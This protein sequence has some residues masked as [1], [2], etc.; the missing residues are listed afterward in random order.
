[1]SSVRLR[2][3][4]HRSGRRMHHALD[5]PTHGRSRGGV[6]SSVLPLLAHRMVIQSSSHQHRILADLI[7]PASPSPSTQRPTS[8][9]RRSSPPRFVQRAYRC[10]YRAF[11]SRRSC[12]FRPHRRRSIAWVGSTIWCL[13]VLPRWSLWSWG[14]F[15]L[16][17]VSFRSN[18]ARGRKES[19]LTRYYAD[20]A[21]II[22]R[23]WGSVW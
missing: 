21:E 6:R 4:R 11:S 5:L 8:T 12:S 23:Y 18:N 7:I 9:P 19:D 16:R 20:T 15:S 17:Y 2:R 13:S 3:V 14:C 22:G 1:M 10:P